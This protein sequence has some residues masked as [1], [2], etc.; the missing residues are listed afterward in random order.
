MLRSSICSRFVALAINDAPLAAA[1]NIFFI[2]FV[3]IYMK[4]AFH[5]TVCL[6]SLCTTKH[7]TKLPGPP[8][9]ERLPAVVSRVLCVLSSRASRIGRSK[10]GALTSWQMTNLFSFRILIL[11][12][13]D[14]CATK[15]LLPHPFDCKFCS[16]YLLVRSNHIK[17]LR[18]D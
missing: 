5:Y 16:H 10:R 1:V 2:A 3:S 18:L 11:F 4:I 12:V 6:I 13:K 7:S 17:Y 14:L 9:P 15:R 8:L